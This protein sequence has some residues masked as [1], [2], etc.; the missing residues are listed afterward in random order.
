MMSH[1]SFLPKKECEDRLAQWSWSVC[2]R[3]WSY[4]FHRESESYQGSTSGSSSPTESPLSWITS[5]LSLFLGSSFLNWGYFDNQRPKWPNL[6]GPF[7]RIP[8]NVPN[9]QKMELLIFLS[10]CFDLWFARIPIKNS[11]FSTQIDV[12][13]SKNSKYLVIV[14]DNKPEGDGP[15]RVY[16]RITVGEVPPR[17]CIERLDPNTWIKN[18]AASAKTK[19]ET[20]YN[21]K[22][23]GTW[24]FSNR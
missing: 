14:V 20:G 12:I 10:A 22:K 15:D 9:S 18:F 8:A 17:V 11:N 24:K 7:F 6:T 13:S 4:L 19:I 1:D 5:G 16:R 3:S 21:S 2:T 23:T